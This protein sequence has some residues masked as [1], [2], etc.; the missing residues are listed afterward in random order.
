MIKL[1]A[2]IIYK[3]LIEIQGL[4][5]EDLK[6]LSTLIIQKQVADILNTKKN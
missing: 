4:A 6:K 2:K 3:I 1:I 5:N